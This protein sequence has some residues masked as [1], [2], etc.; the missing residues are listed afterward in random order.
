MVSLVLVFQ[1]LCQK[2]SYMY[3]FGHE[4]VTFPTTD[5]RFTLYAIEITDKL[6]ITM[7]KKNYRLIIVKILEK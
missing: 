1:V 2:S 6:K 4:P 5:G 3:H 7:N